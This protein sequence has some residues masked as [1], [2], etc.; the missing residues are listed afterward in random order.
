MTQLSNDCFKHNKKRISLEKA[1]SILEK[2]IKCIKK[3]QKIKLDQSLGRILSKDI[4]SKLNVPPFDNTAVDGYA[5]KYSD[6]NKNKE[7]TLKL[8]G[9]I[10]AGQNFNK[11]IKK[12]EVARIFTGAKVPEGTDTVI[13]QEDCNINGIEIILKPGIFKGANIR[14]KGEDIKSKKKILTKGSKLK[15][16]DIALIASIGIKEIEVYEK[17]K[18]GIFTTGNELFEPG[19]KISKNGIYDSNRYCLKNLLE[20]INCSVKDY[21]I[22]K[23]NEKLIKN[24]L[25]KISKE[26]DLIITTGGM[27]VGEEDYVRKVVEKNGSL[28]FWNISIKPGRPVALGNIFKK[29]FIGLPGNPVSVMITFLK[30]ALPA[31]N[32]LSGFLSPKE[33]NFIVTTDFNFKKKSGRKEFLRVKVSKN[34]NGEIKIKHY[35]NTGSGVFTSMVETDGLVE[36]P[37]KLTYLKKGAKVKFVPYSEILL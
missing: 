23:D 28:N 32:K 20:T 29:P 3:T 24:T 1:V 2:R 21:G 14:K 27:S 30:I 17:L 18:V 4:F 8:N 31:I 36:L 6:L 37:E 22:K 10:A 35:P 33:N 7:T 15:A 5:F 25:K 13:M 12:G 16:Q 19:N 9:R 26:C 11:K 34:S